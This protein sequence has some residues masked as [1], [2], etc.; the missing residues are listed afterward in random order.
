MP[1]LIWVFTGRT[2]HFVIPCH[3]IHSEPFWES[4][5]ASF[6]DF[7]LSIFDR[8]SSKVAWTLISGRS[9]LGLQMGKIWLS[10][11]ELWPLIDVKMCFSSLSSEQW[12]NFNKI[13]FMH[14]YIQNPCWSNARY[15]WSIFNRIMALAQCQNFFMLKFLWINLWI[16]IK[17]C[18]CIDIDKK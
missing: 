5:I 6:L 7:N 15:F 9:G 17:F 3:V 8:F 13:L 16:S 12:I 14:W 2:G 4:V 18:I 10:I 11:T 1:R